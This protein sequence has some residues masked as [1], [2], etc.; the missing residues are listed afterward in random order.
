MTASKSFK[1]LAYKYIFSTDLSIEIHYGIFPVVIVLNE[2][3]FNS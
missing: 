1:N 3:E 2:E